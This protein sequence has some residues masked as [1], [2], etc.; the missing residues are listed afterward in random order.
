[1]KLV[2][3]VVWA[4]A[5]SIGVVLL[6]GGAVVDRVCARLARR[7]AL[8]ACLILVF[9]TVGCGG[10]RPPNPPGP[11]PTPTPVP[12]SG[13]VNAGMLLHRD[14]VTIKQSNGLAFDFRGA[15]T[16]CAGD[17]KE[18]P[19][20]I[21]QGWPIGTKK[22]NA[23][24]KAAGNINFV[25]KRV[26]PF[27]TVPGSEDGLAA[28]GG[29]YLEV[30][31]KADLSQWNDVF[32]KYNDD[33]VLDDATR[34]QWSQVGLLDPWGLK[35]GC[36]ADDIP[37]YH[38]WNPVNN[39]QGAAHCSPV[40]DAVQEA[41]VRKVVATL[42]RHGNVTWEVGNESGLLEGWNVAWEEAIISAVRDEETK[43]GYP[44]HLIATNS[45]RVVPSADWDEFHT[46]GSAVALGP[47]I[48][49]VNEYNPEPPIS[50][51]TLAATYCSA[52][53]AGV[54]YWAWR[55][56]MSLAEW[57]KALGLIKA[58]CSGAIAGCPQPDFEAPG[59]TTVVASPQHLDE[60][61][62]AES[63]VRVAHPEWFNGTCLAGGG[64]PPG[65][66]PTHAAERWGLFEKVV[67]AIAEEMRKAGTCAWQHR[68]VEIHSLRTDKFWTELHSV[69]TNDGCK[70]GVPYKN[71]WKQP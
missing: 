5:F 25:S 62:R 59:W 11:L 9:W 48:T 22:G 51:A 67:D 56:G 40:F 39:V 60:L 35:R 19:T 23:W 13:V 36:H 8:A 70:P 29:G 7:L 20:E 33:L 16:C 45:E 17:P 61:G 27:R 63:A 42:G 2:L 68:R 71:T 18:D 37:A 43:H 28:I 58:G 4:V 54:Y 1:M 3:A 6:L 34:D 65:D 10:I 15:K 64:T 30:G 53:A 47:K 14:G 38:A 12:N 55:H 50:G 49:G 66:N 21:D 69:S 57:S 46:N 26:A 41:W 32:W 44:H 24:L 52:R 31:G